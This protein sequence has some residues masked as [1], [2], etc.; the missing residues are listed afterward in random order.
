MYAIYDLLQI[1]E[2]HMHNL[3]ELQAFHPKELFFKH[4][5]DKISLAINGWRE[6]S[7]ALVYYLTDGWLFNPIKLMF[8]QFCTS[9]VSYQNK[10]NPANH[11]VTA[12]ITEIQKL[13]QSFEPIKKTGLYLNRRCPDTWVVAFI[14]QALQYCKMN[15]SDVWI[16]CEMNEE[17]IDNQAQIAELEA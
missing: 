17:I 12:H 6:V 7:M 8:K 10:N 9:N 1:Y 15:P 13:Q 14:V 4:G 16:K 5:N 2:D 11:I 3:K